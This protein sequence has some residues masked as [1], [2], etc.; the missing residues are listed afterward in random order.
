MTQEEQ[1]FRRLLVD[2]E[3]KFFESP[4][5]IKQQQ[6]SKRWNYSVCGTPIQKNKGI[7]LGINWGA[8]GDHEPQMEMPDGEDIPNYNFIQ[9]S[10][11][12]L[13]KYLL[14][15]FYIINFN[16]TNLCFFRTP[17]ESCLNSKD[18]E[19]SLPLFKQF[20]EFVKP[21]WIF[22]LGNN[23]YNI[24]LGLGQLTDVMEYFDSEHK[25][26]G[27]MAKLW[28]HNFYSV[29]HPNARVKKKSRNEIWEHIGQQP[30]LL[31]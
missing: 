6:L 24:L 26:K 3:R 2:T 29:P 7:L 8:D 9:R 5:F 14:L 25:H 22:S 23:N 12:F 13:E 31:A 21:P 4:V 28:G 1:F 27:I 16:Y 19:N 17:K 20:V 30:L 10:R 18:H 15:N 11:P